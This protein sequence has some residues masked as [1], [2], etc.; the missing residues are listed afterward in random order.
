M[1]RLVVFVPMVEIRVVGMRV[2]HGFVLVR[3]RMRFA[4]IPLEFMCMSMVVIMGVQVLMVE[5]LMFVFMHML[6]TDMQPDAQSHQRTS[7][8][9]AQSGSFAQQQQGRRCAD[10]GCSGKIGAR[11][12]STQ[13]AQSQNEGGQTDAVAD[14]PD[15]SGR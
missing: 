7:D 4:P 5:R 12:R 6:L 14:Q 15:G 1:Q 3:V 2:D 10:K 11:A 9:E 8:P 13:M